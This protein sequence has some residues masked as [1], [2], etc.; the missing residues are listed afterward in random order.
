MVKNDV[1]EW[2][3]ISIYPYIYNPSWYSKMIFVN[4]KTYAAFDLC[5][6]KQNKTKQ[7]TLAM[8]RDLGA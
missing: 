4:I 7:K 5:G 2:K 8:F 3:K 1:G 6:L